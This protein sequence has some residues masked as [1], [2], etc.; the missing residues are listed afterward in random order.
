MCARP[1]HLF[2][3]PFLRLYS[4]FHQSPFT[5]HSLCV[6]APLREI[7]LRVYSRQFA[8]IFC[9]P[10]VLLRLFRICSYLCGLSFFASESIGHAVIR[11][12]AYTKQTT[13]MFLKIEARIYC[14]GLIA[15]SGTAN[16]GEDNA[17]VGR[18]ARKPSLPSAPG[19]SQPINVYCIV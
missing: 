6:F 17:R 11:G 12:R 8:V 1:V 14:T 9:V 4:F 18:T 5:F 2:A 3:V 15:H 19:L 10:C 7:F 16:R 13:T